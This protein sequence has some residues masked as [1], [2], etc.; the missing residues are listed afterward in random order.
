MAKNTQKQKHSHSEI[1]PF[2]TSKFSSLQYVKI[3]YVDQNKE[4]YEIKTEVQTINND[5]IRLFADKNDGID[6]TCPCGVALKFVTNDAIYFAKTVL[7]DIKNINNRIV[8]FLDAPR[9][10][11]RQQKRKFFRI[12]MERPCAIFV[13]N[14][15]NAQ[16]YTA[17]SVNISIGGILLYNVE[18]MLNEEEQTRFTPS[19][20]DS[21]YIAIFLE[22]DL[23][24]T[25]CAKFV[26]S[27]YVDG[28]YRYAFQFINMPLKYINPFNKYMTSAELK[29]LKLVKRR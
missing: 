17:Q 14:N 13:N 26:R 10:T 23:K 15:N 29:L 21:C 22:Q 5:T 12:N 19:K 6:I 2:S 25:V 16:A 27:E 18:S 9:K 7:N 11:I 4:L 3:V 1:V 20:D 28:S 8:L 24:I